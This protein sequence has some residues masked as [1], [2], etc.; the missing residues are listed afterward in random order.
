MD[1]GILSV[2][3]ERY[4]PNQR[5][6]EAAA[7]SGYRARL[8]HTRDCLPKIIGGRPGMTVESGGKP[9]ILLP[10]IGATINDYA[11]GVVR[12]FELSGVAVVN[13]IK[14][15][16]L[17]R[18]KFLSLQALAA[19]GLPVPD[20]LLAV[21]ARGAQEAA[22][23]L[24]GYPVVAKM[25]SSRQGQGV[26]RIDS[27]ITSDFV[28]EN[29]QDN[30]R[31]VLVQE[32]LI[33]ENRRDIR[34]FVVG[35]EVVAAMEL[36]PLAG[37]FR[38]NIHLTGSGKGLT[39]DEELSELAVRSAEVLGLEIAGTDIIV[40]KEGTPKIIEV[41]YSPGFRGLEQATG[42]DIASR[43]IGYVS[44]KIMMGK[45]CISPF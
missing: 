20:T 24:G 32:Y 18:N 36:T 27:A 42:V 35:G 7:R 31:G 34:A 39:L 26:L 43:I 15:I 40:D 38:S 3:D 45:P 8:I 13:G 2:Q 33:P 44:H 1:I 5:L 30:S 28:M 14:A 17:A 37:D 29:L 4:P 21:N 16:L 10:R 23:T 22:E 12:H 9:D 41:N 11:L 25:P 6:M 19:A